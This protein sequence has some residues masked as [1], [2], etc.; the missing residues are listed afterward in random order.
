MQRSANPFK[1]TMT[2][3]SLIFDIGFNLVKY[4]FSNFVSSILDSKAKHST[5]ENLSDSWTETLFT[6]FQAER[7]H[8]SGKAS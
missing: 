3:T 6:S 2:K 1:S 4:P 8:L 7:V 5:G